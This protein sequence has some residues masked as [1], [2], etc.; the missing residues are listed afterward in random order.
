[1]DGDG[2][3]AG[4]ARLLGLPSWMPRAVLRTA[5]LLIATAVILAPDTA[6]EAFRIYV[7]V[8]T[9]RIMDVMNS[10]LT[11]ALTK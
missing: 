11:P 10:V 9:E 5:C 6:Q 3:A 8:Q 1:M 2:V 4:L 7:N